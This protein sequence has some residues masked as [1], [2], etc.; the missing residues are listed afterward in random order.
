[1]QKLLQVSRKSNIIFSVRLGFFYFHCINQMQM[2]KDTMHKDTT[3]KAKVKK[4]VPNGNSTQKKGDFHVKKGKIV[5]ALNVKKDDKKEPVVVNKLT[6]KEPGTKNTINIDSKRAN[7]KQPAIKKSDVGFSSSKLKSTKEAKNSNEA[8]KD[9]RNS[10]YK[11]R[12]IRVPLKASHAIA[13]KIVS[14]NISSKNVMNQVHNVTI[15]S[16]PSVR[17]E[18]VSIEEENAKQQMKRQFDHSNIMFDLL[19]RHVIKMLC[20]QHLLNFRDT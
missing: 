3:N 5:N 14:D 9:D 20:F 10:V 12:A 19:F 16:P 13:A 4:S 2:T 6:T 7:S 1:M 18:I 17:R 8:L 11:R 15:S